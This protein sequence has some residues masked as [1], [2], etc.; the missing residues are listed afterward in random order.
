MFFLKYNLLC[1]WFSFLGFMANHICLGPDLG[2][3]CPYLAL[4]NLIDSCTSH[5]HAQ[6]QLN[7]AKHC[8]LVEASLNHKPKERR[9]NQEGQHNKALHEDGYLDDFLWTA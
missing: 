4:A 7:H 3:D 1:V 6:P 2:I 8:Q 5:C 9:F